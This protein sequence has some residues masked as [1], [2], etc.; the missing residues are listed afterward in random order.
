MSLTCLRSRRNTHTQ[1]SVSYN[2][3]FALEGSVF[4]LSVCSLYAIARLRNLEPVFITLPGG[5]T[6]CASFSYSGHVWVLRF[7]DVYIRYKVSFSVA[8]IVV[9]LVT[10]KDITSNACICEEREL[11]AHMTAVFVSDRARCTRLACLHF[12]DAT[13]AVMCASRLQVV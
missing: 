13:T 7:A 11:P 1:N 4:L 3:S 6:R 5:G 10:G 2:F 12:T 9:R 8:I